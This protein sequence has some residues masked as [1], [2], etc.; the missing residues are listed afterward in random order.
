MARSSLT[1]VVDRSPRSFRQFSY[2]TRGTVRN[3]VRRFIHRAFYPTF[4]LPRDVGD[5]KPKILIPDWEIGF[6]LQKF[7]N[8]IEGLTFTSFYL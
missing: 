5:P 2:A 4:E 7:D 6:V 3:A 1:S 8:S